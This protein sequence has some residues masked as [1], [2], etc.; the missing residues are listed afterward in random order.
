[1]KTFLPKIDPAKRRWVVVDLDG[2][3]LGRTAVIVANKLTGKDKPIFTRHIDTGDHVVAINA[4]GVKVKGA[5][6]PKQQRY[7][8]YSGY[9]GGLRTVTLAEKMEKKP[10]QVFSL[11]VRRM[12]PKNRLGR[13]M[14]KKLYV[15]AGPEHPHG[16]QKPE[17]IDSIKRA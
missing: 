6:K 7:Y 5:N 12:L 2:A 9:P 3:N 16:A 14:F 10:E 4:A 15:Y 13:K 1:M 11:A 17:P 8:S